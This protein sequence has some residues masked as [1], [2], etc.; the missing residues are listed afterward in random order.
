MTQR[1]LT[2]KCLDTVFDVT[3]DVTNDCNNYHT[4]IYG[5]KSGQSVERES[6][7]RKSINY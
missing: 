5:T 7:N 1:A 6:L 3:C 2:D 4:T